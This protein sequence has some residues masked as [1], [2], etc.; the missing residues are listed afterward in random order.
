M[1]VHVRLPW[2][3]YPRPRGGTAVLRPL[4]KPLRGLSPP[5]RGN[6]YE[7][8]HSVPVPGSIPAH[9]GEPAAAMSDG[10]RGRVYPRPRGGT[11]MQ[12]TS[13]DAGFGLSPPTRGNLSAITVARD[14]RRSIPAHAGE[15]PPGADD[16]QV[17]E[18]YPRP[19]GGTRLYSSIRSW[20]CG[21]S[22]PTRGNR[23]LVDHAATS[24]GSIPA[25]AGEP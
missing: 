24:S 13:T 21:L 3:V 25:H 8:P 14:G 4:I 11:R 2:A 17:N 1:F 15:P 23:Q 18:V 9:A 10:W 5:T 12:G 19:R 7:R 22:P 20:A 6:P 16:W